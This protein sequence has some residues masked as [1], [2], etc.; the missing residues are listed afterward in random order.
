MRPYKVYFLPDMWNDWH[1]SIYDARDNLVATSDRG[2]FHL[3]DAQ[4]E[5]EAVMLYRMAS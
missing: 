5:A 2:H 4:R 1:W 3:I